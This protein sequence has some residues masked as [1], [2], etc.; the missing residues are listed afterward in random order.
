MPSAPFALHRD[1]LYRRVWSKPAK[2]VARD[3]GISVASLIRICEKLAIPHPTR[4]YWARHEA[5]LEESTPLPPVRDRP[6]KHEFDLDK[7]VRFYRPSQEARR[8]IQAEYRRNT[9]VRASD[10][11]PSHP[12]VVAAAPRLT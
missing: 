6:S 8:L 5:G 3:L 9:Q 11:A 10:E 1:I 12:L 4:G 7:S 2:A